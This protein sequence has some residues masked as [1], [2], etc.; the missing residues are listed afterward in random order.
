MEELDKLREEIDAVDAR[1]LAALALRRNLARQV[2]PA[3][4]AVVDEMS[5]RGE[6]QRSFL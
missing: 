6:Y 5:E 3:G 1:I 2:I 4:D